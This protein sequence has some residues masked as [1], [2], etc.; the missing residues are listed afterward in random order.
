M[1]PSATGGAQP[2]R[3]YARLVR[4]PIVFLLAGGVVLALA[5]CGESPADEDAS[6][7]R[8]ASTPR[9]ATQP[10]TAPPPP[11]PAP[12]SAPGPDVC[13]LRAGASNI[14]H[15]EAALWRGTLDGGGLLRIKR[16]ASV[17]EA[18][19]VVTQALDIHAKNVGRYAVLGT[20]KRTGSKQP[21]STAADCLANG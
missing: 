5:S 3:K 10:R 12:S 13:L 4:S 11:R 8:V 9:T 7:G 14:D 21:V 15:P 2:S 16:F 1:R 6:T 18:K 19:D 20:A 17:S